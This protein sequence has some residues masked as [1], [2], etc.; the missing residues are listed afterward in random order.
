M[1]EVFLSYARE[2]KARAEQVAHG[3]A[4]AGVQVFWDSEIPPGQTWADYI[5]TKLTQCKALIVLWSETSTKSQWVREEARMGRDKGVLIPAMIDGALAPFGFGE[6]QAANLASWNGEADHPDWRRFVD[7]VRAAASRTEPPRAPQPAPSAPPRAQPAM[8]ASAAAEKKGVPT[9][10][11]VLGGVAAAV[12]GLGVLGAM[13][14][15]SANQQ[16]TP[17]VNPVMA[18]PAPT[19]QPTPQPLSVQQYQEQVLQ[20]L[21]VMEQA[22]GVEG[23]QRMADPVSGQLRQGEQQDWPVTLE[24]GGEFRVIGACDSDCADLD[25]TLFDGYGNVISQD[26]SVDA[27]PIVSVVPTTSGQFM[28]RA[29]MYNC[30]VSPCYYALSLH[31]RAM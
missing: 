1:G 4:A 7:A 20:R 21:A 24:V 2:D 18:T 11:W 12:V 6:V 31:G 27:N 19:P 15:D 30:A 16:Q 5:E 3:L 17:A 28:V 26:T 13:L 22:V 23:F 9:W 10:A 8:S 29:H 25:L 14:P